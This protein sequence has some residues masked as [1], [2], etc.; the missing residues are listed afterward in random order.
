VIGGDPLIRVML[1][2]NHDVLRSTL[3]AIIG[4]REGL[5]LVA[6]GVDGQEAVALYAQ[7]LPDV[8]LMDVKMPHMNGIEATRAIVQR[9]PL[10]KIIVCSI[11]EDKD[12]AAT[13]L[14][15]GAVLFLDKAAMAE[16][17][18]ERIHQAHDGL[19]GTL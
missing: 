11:Y 19:P 4:S 2:E 8:V 14:Q 15:A 13:A 10:A 1:V 7:H 18:Y 3:A 12:F 9:F 16:Q 17:L 5:E 6:E